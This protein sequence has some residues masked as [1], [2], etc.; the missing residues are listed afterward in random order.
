MICKFLN[1]QDYGDILAAMQQFTKN[2]NVDTVDEIWFLEHYAVFTQ[3]PSAKNDHVLGD[4]KVINTDRGG[5]ITYHAPGQLIVYFL[6]DLVRRA[7][8]LK[9]LI[10]I[11]SQSII[12]LLAKYNIVGHTTDGAPGVY[13]NNNKICSIGLK[14]SKGCTYHGLSL[15][16]NM[17][18]QPFSQINPCG[19][20]NL[21][22]TQL[23][24]F[25]DQVD[26]QAVIAEYSKILTM[27]LGNG[28]KL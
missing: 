24:N 13:I 4:I 19:Y 26:M 17:N 20:P 23:S 25:V 15:N 12:N 5:Q 16:V 18:L 21:K 7:I 27:V 9:K 28:K 8:N 2:R 1:I 10:F 6:L 11:L 22:M 3:G 14:I